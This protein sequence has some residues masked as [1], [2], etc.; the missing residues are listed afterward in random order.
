MRSAR[1]TAA[2]RVRTVSRPCSLQQLSSGK[3]IHSGPGSEQWTE[4]WQ[5][6]ENLLSFTAPTI[7]GPLSL[8]LS[9]CLTLQSDCRG[10]SHAHTHTQKSDAGG[11][12]L[13]WY[14]CTKGDPLLPPA[15]AS[16]S[17]SLSLSLPPPP[18]F[19]LLRP[20]RHTCSEVKRPA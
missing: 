20:L 14:I 1:C 2:P 8:S 11:R 7:S 19:L 13:G 16:L 5:N 6:S 4:M 18:P 15:P 9:H 12:S 10:L 3:S 17:P